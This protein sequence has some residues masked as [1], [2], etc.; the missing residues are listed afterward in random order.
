MRTTPAFAVRLPD[1]PTRGDVGDILLSWVTK[2][3]VTF[4]VLGVLAF[5]G[6][7]VIATRLQ[8][9][10]AST[11]DAQAASDAWTQTHVLQKAYDA[12][13]AAS[14]PGDTI[15]PTSFRVDPG[16][17]VHLT[18]HRTAHTLVLQRWSRTAGWA[19]VTAE[20]DAGATP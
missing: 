10:D 9:A 18:L 16:G 14:R 3:A 7:A 20:G 19:S 12:A 8:A 1:K 17:A 13:V 11:A 5:D 15:T 4:A 6:L 2:L